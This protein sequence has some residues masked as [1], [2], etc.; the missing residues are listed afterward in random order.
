MKT[1]WLQQLK[2]PAERDQFENIFKNSDF[3]L[4]KLKEILYNVIKDKQKSK[5][6]D[7]DNPSWAYKQAHINGYIKGLEDIIQLLEEKDNKD[8]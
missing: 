1:K 5:I 3:L 6:I 7:Y 8:E 2:T 4:D